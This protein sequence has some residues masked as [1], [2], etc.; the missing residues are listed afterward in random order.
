MAWSVGGALNVV[1]DCREQFHSG[2]TGSGGAGVAYE[3]SPKN[4]SKVASSPAEPKRELKSLGD[5]RL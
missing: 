5:L 4:E 1:G 3:Q 2:V